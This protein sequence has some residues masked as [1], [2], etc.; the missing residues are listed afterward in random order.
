MGFLLSSLLMAGGGG[1]PHELLQYLTVEP[2]S[3]WIILNVPGSLT[4]SPQR[5]GKK[6]KKKKKKKERMC[7]QAKKDYG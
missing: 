1:G 7:R 6:E 3:T 2:Q 4:K 5:S